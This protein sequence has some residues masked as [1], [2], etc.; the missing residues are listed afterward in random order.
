M[1]FIEERSSRNRDPRGAEV[2]GMDHEIEEVW[3]HVG[4]VL[5]LAAVVRPEEAS[6]CQAAAEH[7]A[8]HI[9]LV[10]PHL[11]PVSRRDHVLNYRLLAAF[12]SFRQSIDTICREY[13]DD[14][15]AFELSDPK[16]AV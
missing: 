4:N 14:I 8:V 6:A 12:S 10:D 11:P 1:F 5:R 3:M 16:P 13:D 9:L 7:H 15:S 2:D